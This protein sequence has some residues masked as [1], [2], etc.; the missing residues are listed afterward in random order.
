VEQLFVKRKLSPFRGNKLM[1]SGKKKRGKKRGGK[2]CVTQGGVRW[3]RILSQ[4]RKQ[5]PEG[6]NKEDA[7]E[8]GFIWLKAD[9]ETGETRGRWG[10]LCK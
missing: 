6:P 4:Q 9:N 10:A 5:G 8:R 7:E 1:S 3:K 2:E